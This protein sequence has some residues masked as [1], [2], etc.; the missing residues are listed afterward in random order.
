MK[1]KVLTYAGF[2]AIMI[3]LGSNDA[4]KGIFAPIFQDHFRLSGMQL[5][6]IVTVSYAGN[7][8]F[9]LA[10]GVLADRWGRKATMITAIVVWLT[11][12]LLFI[13]TD[14]YPLLLVGMFFSMGASTLISMSINVVTPAIFVAM[15]A[16][17]VN[18]L[19]FI[20][21]IGLSGSQSIIGGLATDISAWKMTNMVL[22]AAGIVA[23]LVL[24]WVKLPENK[25]AKSGPNSRAGNL[26]GS[27]A[28]DSSD[29]EAAV[30]PAFSSYFRRTE[31]WAFVLIFGFYFIAEHGVLNWLVPY[32]TNELDM[33]MDK[34]SRYLAIFF[35]GMT[36]GRLLLSPLVDKLGVMRSIRLFGAASGVLYITGVLVGGQALILLSISGLLMS[37]IYPTLVMSIQQFWRGPGISTVTGMIISVASLF[38]ILFNLLFGRMIDTIGYQVSF[39]ILPAS[40][41]AFCVLFWL[42]AFRSAKKTIPAPVPAAQG[43]SP[44]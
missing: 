35:G 22:F 44:V 15:P 39:L 10:G 28:E 16:F 26:G 5:A 33:G 7:M 37:I 14:H 4:L 1:N 2:M 6:L 38:D 11:S 34:A 9:L 40:M 20:Q 30:R 29:S 19:F 32:A 43:K 23:I 25:A 24:V 42:F 21:G 13:T 8:L 18:S 12:L 3:A 17:A 36:A 27:H 41:A 31:F